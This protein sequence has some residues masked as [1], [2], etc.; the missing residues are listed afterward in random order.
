MEITKHT[1]DGIK[2]RLEV[3][4]GVGKSYYS[5]KWC[6]FERHEWHLI[7]LFH[8]QNSCWFYWIVSNAK[9]TVL[10]YRKRWIWKFIHIVSQIFNIKIHVFSYIWGKK[11]SWHPDLPGNTAFW[12]FENAYVSKCRNITRCHRNMVDSAFESWWSIFSDPK[13]IFVIRTHP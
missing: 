2:L 10:G 9:N 3:P 7:F 13:K 8:I 12:G 6:T 1:I 11:S 4:S 5:V